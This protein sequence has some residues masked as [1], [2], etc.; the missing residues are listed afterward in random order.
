LKLLAHRPATIQITWLGFPGTLGQTKEKI[1]KENESQ[2][3]TAIDVIIGDQYV[4]SPDIAGPYISERLVLFPGTYQPQDELQGSSSHLSNDLTPSFPVISIKS[5]DKYKFRIDFINQKFTS[6]A[7][8]SA[9]VI[10]NGFWFISFNRLSKVTEEAFQDWMQILIRKV[11]GDKISVL[12]LM[13]ESTEA[14]IQIK[15]ILV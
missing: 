14:E 10:A 9:D 1:S 8:Y 2:F 15:V 4:S 7:S 11:T 3:K 6:T 5:Q 12:L 13:A